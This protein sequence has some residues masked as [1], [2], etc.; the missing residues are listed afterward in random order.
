MTQRLYSHD[1]SLQTG[2]LT[3]SIGQKFPSAERMIERDPH[4]RR[5]RRDVRKRTGAAST[6]LSAAPGAYFDR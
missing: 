3:S 5:P 2:S 6:A 1:G 4:T